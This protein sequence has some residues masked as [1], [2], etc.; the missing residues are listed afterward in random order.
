MNVYIDCMMTVADNSVVE[1]NIP[2][3]INGIQV[4]SVGQENILEVNPLGFWEFENLKK[5]SI[6]ENVKVVDGFYQ[7]SNISQIVLLSTVTEIVSDA[8]YW[9]FKLNNL[10]IPKDLQKIGSNAFY[11][12][13]SMKNTYLPDNVNCLE[14]MCFG[15]SGLEFV[16]LPDNL[17][18]LK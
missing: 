9:W 11:D 2:Q 6:P 12:C 5:V 13:Y 8:F 1:V 7:C 14:E 16:K 17:K 4:I 18:Y 3:I 10:V 15:E